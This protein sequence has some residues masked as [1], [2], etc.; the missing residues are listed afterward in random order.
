MRSAR[1]AAVSSCAGRV[2][3]P[4]EPRRRPLGGAHAGRPLRRRAR[5]CAAGR[6]RGDRGRGGGRARRRRAGRDR[7][8]LP[9]LREP[10]GRG[11]PQRRPDGG[12]ARRAAGLRRRRDREPPL[13]VGSLGGR[14]RLPCDRGRRRRPLRRRRGR[15][16]EP[17]AAR[18]G[19]ARRRLSRAATARCTTRRSAGASRIRRS[20][21]RFP[22]ETMGETGENVAERW[23]RLARGSGRVRAPLAAAV[24]RGRLLRG[25]RAGRRARSP[26]SIRGRTRA[27]RS[28]RR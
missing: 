22:L 13:R 15:V 2:G 3:S 8:R 7:G 10:G 11:Q 23:E 28:W 21:R 18:D 20:R 5:R 27:A 9:R 14:R 6:P 26:T 12:A 17:R 16:D 25:A 4:R 24:G 1:T 19:E